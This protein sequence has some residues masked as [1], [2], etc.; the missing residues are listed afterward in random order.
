MNLWIIKLMTM[1]K[2]LHPKDDT[3]YMRQEKLEEEDSPALK[4]T[5]MHQY[6]DSKTLK[7]SKKDYLQQLVTDMTT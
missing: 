3:D 2:P 4:I 5:W 1:H 7:G 6:V